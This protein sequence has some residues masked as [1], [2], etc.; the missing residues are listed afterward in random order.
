MKPDGEKVSESVSCSFW[1]SVSLALYIIKHTNGVVDNPLIF[2]NG[3]KF[4]FKKLFFV[5]MKWSYQKN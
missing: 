2:W 3:R 5:E 4:F 1:K